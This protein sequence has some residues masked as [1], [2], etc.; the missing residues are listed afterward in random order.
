MSEE[1]LIKSKKRV[2]NH[3]EVFTPKRIV[4]KMINQDGVKESIQ[5]IRKTILEPSAGEGV[6][7]TE[8]L[9]KR[10]KYL[11]NISES[12]SNYENESLIAIS[13]LYGVELLEDNAQKCVTNIYEV[14]LEN[15]I[16]AGSKF[17]CKLKDKVKKSAKTIIA[18]NIIQGDFLKE[19]DAYGNPLIFSEWKE[20]KSKSNKIKIQRTEYTLEDIR[21]KNIKQDGVL[22]KK[23]VVNNQLDFF[24]EDESQIENLVSRYVPSYIDEI[25]K[26]EIEESV[27]V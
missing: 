25:Y 15:Y 16:E 14:F 3:G 10:L 11:L 13:T 2:K 6:F 18:A 8:I 9:K 26:E 17:K 7:L 5:D 21:A 24:G 12:I 23:I 20:I 1:K 27:N 22:E 19:K 4:H